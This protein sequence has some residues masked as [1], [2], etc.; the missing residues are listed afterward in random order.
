MKMAMPM[1]IQTIQES[2]SPQDT[3]KLPIFCGVKIGRRNLSG[4]ARIAAVS[5]LATG[6]PS[7]TRAMPTEALL[8]FQK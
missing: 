6:P 3:T 1:F 4:M 5:R 2:S 7:P 8:P